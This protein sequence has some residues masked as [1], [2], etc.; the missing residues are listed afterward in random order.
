MA[1][2]AP[3]PPL[4]RAEDIRPPLGSWRRLYGLVLGALVLEVGMLWALARAFG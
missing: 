2:D 3:R 1:A 4:A